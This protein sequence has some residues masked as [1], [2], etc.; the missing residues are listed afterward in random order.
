MTVSLPPIA[1]GNMCEVF[2]TV[3]VVVGLPTA[4]LTNEQVLESFFGI[5]MS[6]LMS[7]PI[8]AFVF[9]LACCFIRH[10]I[11]WTRPPE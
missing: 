2:T 10:K 5:Q 4:I 7:V 6:P 11:P 8:T 3:I 1:H 9:W